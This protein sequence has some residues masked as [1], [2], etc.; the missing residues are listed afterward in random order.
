MEATAQTPF[1]LIFLAKQ[2][3]L[4][5]DKALASQL[6][7][8]V[9]ESEPENTDAM[10]IMAGVSDPQSSLNYLNRVL[11]ID[12]ANQVAY[13][14]MK[15]ASQR[16]RKVSSAAWTPEATASVLPVVQQNPQ[17]VQTAPR[18]KL[19][20]ASLLPWLLAFVAVLGYGLWSLGVLETDPNS[21]GRTSIM[22][23]FSSLIPGKA[24][25]VGELTK[26]PVKTTKPTEAAVV[27][28]VVLPSETST[29]TPTETATEMP[30]PTYTST[31]TR[32]N[33]PTSTYTSTAT[34]T[35]TSTSTATPAFTRTSTNTLVPPTPTAAITTPTQ[36]FDPT[37]G[38]PIIQIT[39]L[40]YLIEE[41]DPSEYV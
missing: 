17:S 32:T 6:A 41:P 22:A 34:S 29:E 7:S 30:S 16:L 12:P 33:T 13:Q 19:V 39:P 21:V 31:S 5:G 15:W 1:D 11:A 3:I 38:L 4:N 23:M 26:T 2:A 24:A 27:P 28:L 35:S 20:F 8:S 10:L 9:L 36:E 18:K 25:P 37:S 14:G 40:V